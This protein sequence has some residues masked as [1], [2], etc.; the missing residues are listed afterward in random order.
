M[1]IDIALF[2]LKSIYRPILIFTHNDVTYINLREI[3][4]PRRVNCF[5]PNFFKVL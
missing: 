3:Y 2:K 1:F 5:K 4:V